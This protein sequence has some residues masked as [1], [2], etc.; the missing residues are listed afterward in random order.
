MALSFIETNM[1]PVHPRSVW[2]AYKN[3]ESL[4]LGGTGY[5][6][7]LGV[8]KYKSF[9]KYIHEKFSDIEATEN[10]YSKMM[11]DH[12]LRYEH[13]A[14]SAFIVNT[15]RNKMTIPFERLGYSHEYITDNDTDS[16]IKVIITP[17]FMFNDLSDGTLHILEVK[18]PY[19]LPHSEKY[20][21]YRI[22]WVGELFA[23]K[24][25]PYGVGKP[26]AQ[27]LLYSHVMK[28]NY[29][30]VLNY[31]VR[32]KEDEYCGVLYKYEYKSDDKDLIDFLNNSIISYDS[33]LKSYDENKKYMCYKDG[34]RKVEEMMKKCFISVQIIKGK[35]DQA[36]PV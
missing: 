2:L 20:S 5:P 36:P 8:V 29:F 21:R 7:F 6:I 11:I 14:I 17:D 3:A 13:L 15:F 25:Y 19:H 32:D 26:F 16:K 22:Q 35:R 23:T 31:L 4:A 27:A 30:Y 9:N 12:G 10:N 34:P 24:K 28:A 33:L 1:I 18:C